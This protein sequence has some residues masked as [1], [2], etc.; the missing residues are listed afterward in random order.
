M[1]FDREMRFIGLAVQKQYL[2]LEEK[3]RLRIAHENTT[4]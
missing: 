3:N 1:S 4:K 2:T